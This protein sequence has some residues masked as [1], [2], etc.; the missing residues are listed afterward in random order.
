[1]FGV[2]TAL[3]IRPPNDGHCV[4]MTNV[5]DHLK[6][7]NSRSA[8]T[9]PPPTLARPEQAH[10]SSEI[11]FDPAPPSIEKDGTRHS[12]RFQKTHLI[13]LRRLALLQLGTSTYLSAES[14]LTTNLARITRMI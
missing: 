8:P 10:E 3:V 9:D 2:Y 14:R 11:A 4:L 13:R 1:M 5:A 6:M 12:F 7:R